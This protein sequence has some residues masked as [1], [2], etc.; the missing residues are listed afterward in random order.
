VSQTQQPAYDFPDAIPV[1]PVPAGT[2]LL[3]TGP[4]LGGTR[5]LLLRLLTCGREEGLVLVTA[6]AHGT[7]AIA[8]L[9]R[10]GCAY[11]TSRMAVV[12][13][14][15]DGE[16]DESRNIHT[17]SA[18]GDLTGIG[19]A[20][21]SLYERLYAAGFER[22]RTGLDSLAPLVMF[23]EEIQPIYRFLHTVTGRI[24]SAGGLGVAAIDPEAQEETAFR[25]LA[26]PFDGE[27]QF[28]ERDNT[29]QLRVRGL[30]DQPEGWQPV[31]R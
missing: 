21:S 8:A 26:Q 30:A 29:P 10:A 15:G 16:D 3:V 18:P 14:T 7:D 9:E 6:D 5:D 20:Y 2:S 11:D 28:R 1:E 23:A 12:D 17:V 4:A 19:I 31:G 24:R 22:V 27:L 25:T 13:C